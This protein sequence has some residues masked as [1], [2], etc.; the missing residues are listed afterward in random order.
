M[1]ALTDPNAREL[2]KYLVSCALP[3]SASVDITVEGIDYSYPG[4]LGLAPEWGEDGGSCGKACQGWVSACVLARVNY[5]GLTENV[6]VRGAN[7]ALK[8]T[9]GE[10]STYTS[11]EATYY[12]NIFTSPQIRYACLSPDKTQIPRVCG[13][14]I[15]GCVMDVVG[16]CEDVCGHARADGSF[17]DCWSQAG[18]DEDDAA[19]GASEYHGSITVFLKP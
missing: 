16:S 7:R 4:Q 11:R 9:H 12:G 10:R 18:V 14:S 3:A 8:T 2:L 5:L 1:A 19:P 13:P 15:Q 6:S 17:P